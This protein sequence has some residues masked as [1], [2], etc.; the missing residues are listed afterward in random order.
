MMSS[1]CPHC[2]YEYRDDENA[3]PPRDYIKEKDGFAYS[4]LAET[5]LSVGMV[6][7]A[8]SSI[9]AILGAVILLFRGQWLGSLAFFLGFWYQLALFVIFLRVAA[10]D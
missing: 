3:A 7:T 1:L 4:T 10:D 2:G 5:A 8:I 9:A 6:C